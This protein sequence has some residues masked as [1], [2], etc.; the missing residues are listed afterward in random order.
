MNGFTTASARGVFD[1][2]LNDRTR[3]NGANLIAKHFN[4]SIAQHFYQPKSQ[5]LEMTC[6]EK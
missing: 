2:V 5:Q 1:Y 3:S 6:H 4:L